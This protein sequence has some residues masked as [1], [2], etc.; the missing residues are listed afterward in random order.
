MYENHSAKRR[1][2]VLAFGGAVFYFIAGYFVQ[3]HVIYFAFSGSV[4]R[5]NRQVIARGVHQLE[6]NR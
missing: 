1:E 5:G 4:D 6:G 3:R 2:Y